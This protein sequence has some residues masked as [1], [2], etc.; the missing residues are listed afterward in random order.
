ML[1]GAA[2]QYELPL[3][4]H[5]D[6]HDHHH[7]HHRHGHRHGHHRDLHVPRGVQTLFLSY[8]KDLK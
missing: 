5:H 7:G 4:D 1:S 6:H 3:H 8:Q 2:Y